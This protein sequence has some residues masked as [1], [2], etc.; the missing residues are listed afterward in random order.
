MPDLLVAHLFRSAEETIGRVIHDN[1][2]ATH[3]RER[4][5]DYP[6]HRRRIGHV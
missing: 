2:N 5:I 6:A 1:I 3:G 4:T